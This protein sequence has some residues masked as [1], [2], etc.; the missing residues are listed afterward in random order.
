MI[1]EDMKALFADLKRDI[2]GI[3]ADLIV[4]R[5]DIEQIDEKLEIM[6]LSQSSPTQETDPFQDRRFTQI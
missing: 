2:A 3:K 5:Y 1:G 6:K 4:M